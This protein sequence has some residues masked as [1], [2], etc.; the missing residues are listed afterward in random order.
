MKRLRLLHLRARLA[1]SER[2]VRRMASAIERAEGL[3]AGWLLVPENAE[4]HAAWQASR[5]LWIAAHRR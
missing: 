4:R 5:Q 3:P 1:W 2:R